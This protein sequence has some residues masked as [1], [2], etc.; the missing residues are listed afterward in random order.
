MDNGSR[1][2][3]ERD[4]ERA[5]LAADVEAFLRRGGRIEEVATGAMTQSER[6]NPMR[7]PPV[8]AGDLADA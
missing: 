4:R 1:D 3:S 2:P 5:R 8:K 6:P 7:R